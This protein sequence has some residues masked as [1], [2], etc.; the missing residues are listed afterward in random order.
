MSAGSDS[1]HPNLG[2]T[3][4][5]ITATFAAQGPQALDQVFPVG[6]GFVV[7][8]VTERQKP[9]PED[10]TKK[11]DEL[12]EQARRAKQIEL[13]QSYLKA[14]KETGKVL[15]NTEAIESVVGAS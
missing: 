11:K 14:L 12:R 9:S 7:A 6:E 3:P 4:E 2:P 8:Q 13:E 5:L 1:V 10:F 15:T